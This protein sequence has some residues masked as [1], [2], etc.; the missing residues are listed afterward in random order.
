MNPAPTPDLG[1]AR[2]RDFESAEILMPAAARRGFLGWRVMAG[3]KTQQLFV[4]ERPCGVAD[5]LHQR[6]VHSRM[7]QGFPHL[8]GRAPR[9]ERRPNDGGVDFQLRGDLLDEI[10]ELH[11]TPVD[12]NPPEPREDGGRLSV[13]SNSGEA[14]GRMINCAIRAPSSTTKSWPE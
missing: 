13:S 9:Q 8:L 10:L 7:G 6:A 3:I 4:D 5:P 1:Y 11:S 12:P 2:R 14:I